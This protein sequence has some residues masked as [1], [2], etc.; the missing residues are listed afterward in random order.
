MKKKSLK[1]L[2][3]RKQNRQ[4]LQAYAA[5]LNLANILWQKLQG[6]LITV[7]ERMVNQLGYKQML[8]W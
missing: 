8:L 5:I 7:K 2:E 1:D 6:M 3:V 4:Q